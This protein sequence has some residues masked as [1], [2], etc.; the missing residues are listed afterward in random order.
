MS[1]MLLMASFIK[2]LRVN[3]NLNELVI[4]NTLNAKLKRLI[5]YSQDQ[6]NWNL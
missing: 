6:L 5:L 3:I 2:Y 1:M 4:T